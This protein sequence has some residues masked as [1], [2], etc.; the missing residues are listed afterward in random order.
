M[1]NTTQ[2]LVQK[3]VS[4]KTEDEVIKPSSSTIVRLTSKASTIARN[5]HF[6]TVTVSTMAGTI[7]FGAVGGAFG[8]ASGVVCG[9]VVGVVP[10][11]FTFGASIPAGAVIGALIGTPLGATTGGATG[12][13]T[14]GGS[15]H[16]V[17]VYR[18]EINR[19]YLRLKGSTIEVVSTTRQRLTETASATRQFVTE[20][21][22]RTALATKASVNARALATKESVLATKKFTAEIAAATADRTT[23]IV[24][25][26]SVHVGAASAAAGAVGGATAG[27]AVGLL[28]GATTG[29]LVGVPFALFTFGASIP[30]CAALGGG[31]GMSAGAA[32]GGA[33]AA[34]AAGVSGYNGHK[35][36]KEISS[37]ATS[38][39]GKTV[40]KSLNLRNSAQQSLSALIGGTGGT[41]SE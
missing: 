21:A 38:A 6:Q 36:R 10:A 24:T 13:L 18:H 41:G 34:T 14:C 4:D 20:T 33:A 15:A 31:L 16:G 17:Y 12:A 35:Y 25:D 30:L 8:C 29:G 28:G 19:G 37:G 5:P 27:G 7:T 40:E 2:G 26:R 1:A 11:I 3:N 39:W 9:G 22:S 23:A 32:T